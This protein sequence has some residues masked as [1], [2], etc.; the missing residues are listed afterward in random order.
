MI[1]STHGILFIIPIPGACHL[2]LNLFQDKA[3]VIDKV[4][5]IQRRSMKDT[6]SLGIADVLAARVDLACVPK[7]S[8]GVVRDNT[9]TK[10]NKM[11]IV[12]K[13]CGSDREKA[14]LVTDPLLCGCPQYWD[15]SAGTP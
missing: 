9:K 15:K 2:N 10:L 13:V 3:D 4:Y 1:L 6:S 12:G 8:S 7:T 14:G 11:V 5:N